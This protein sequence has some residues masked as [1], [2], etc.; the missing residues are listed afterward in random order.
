MLTFLLCMLVASPV[1]VES[2]ATIEALA[3]LVLQDQYGDVH[4]LADH[5]G[6]VV[7]AMVV[8]AK[9]LRNIK[10]WERSL[11]ELIDGVAYLRIADIPDDSPASYASV[12]AK[13][14]ER[15]PDGV[16][17]LIDMERVWATRLG[18]DTSRPNILIFDRA[19]RLVS[20]SQGLCTP[21]L[22]APVVHQLE[23][24]AEAP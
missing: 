22:L 15:V 14:G 21:E 6:Q 19:G 4:S 5:R 1:P 24:T 3:S 8:T 9:R 7:V 18:L 10:P 20:T 11:R 12:A 17:V 13:L 2:P 16:P 23:S